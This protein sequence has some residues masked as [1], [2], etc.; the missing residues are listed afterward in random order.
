MFRKFVIVLFVSVLLTSC[1]TGNGTTSSNQ[2]MPV[3]EAP[4]QSAVQS[5]SDNIQP[6]TQPILILPDGVPTPPAL[7]SGTPTPNQITYKKLQASIG[8]IEVWNLN[9]NSV[10]EDQILAASSFGLTLCLADGPIPAGDLIAI[11]LIGGTVIYVFAIAPHIQ[12]IAHFADFAALAETEFPQGSWEKE[13]KLSRGTLIKLTVVSTATF[14]MIIGSTMIYWPDNKTGT[15]NKDHAFV[16]SKTKQSACGWRDVADILKG[17]ADQIKS[18]ADKIKAFMKESSEY[19]DLYNQFIWS[20]MQD[21]I[22]I[23]STYYGL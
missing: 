21:L 16:H 10:G 18:V 13:I 9:G 4:T 1:A 22:E 2:P 8:E 3:P 20:T 15:T 23:L 19:F 7:P 14:C 12:Q 5:T 11:L 17:L 6:S